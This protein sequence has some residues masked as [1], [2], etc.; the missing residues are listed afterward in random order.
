MEIKRMTEQS[1]VGG[2]TP[3]HTPTAQEKEIFAEA[4]SRLIGAEYQPLQV[5]SQQ[6]NGVNYQYA[7]DQTIP[8]QNGHRHVAVEIYVPI[9]GEPTITAIKP[10]LG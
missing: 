7:A 9:G 5:R 10:L 4:T 8:G 6:V 1:I 2:W 3:L